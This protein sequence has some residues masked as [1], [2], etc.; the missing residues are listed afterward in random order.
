M[1]KLSFISS[2]MVLA[3]LSSC[4][5]DESP[6][7]KEQI[8]EVVTHEEPLSAIEVSNQINTLFEQNGS[9]NWSQAS[10]YLLWSAAINGDNILTI[11]YGNEGESFSTN[12]SN[13]LIQ[14]KDEIIKTVLTTSS[15][16][17]KKREDILLYDDPILNNIDVIITDF[18]SVVELRKNNQIRY[19]EPEGFT[20][21]NEN[22][23]RSS[24]GC[25]QSGETISSSDY[26]TL[27]SG[28]KVPWNFYD[29]NIDDAWAYSTG[30]GIGVGV[31][32]TGVS[33]KQSYL[34]SKFD[35]A[36]SGRT[37]SKYGTY[38][39]SIWPWKT[40]TDGPD[41]KCG[42]GTSASATIAAPNNTA[43]QFVGVAYECNLVSYR[44]TSD[45]VLNGYHERKGVSKALV[46]LG[47]RND[48]KIISMSI[49]Y[50]WSIGSIKDAIR[51][52]YSKNKLIFAAGGTSTDFT[53]WYGVIFP[54]TMSETV[55]VT[56]VEE[57]TNYQECDVCHTG[58]D[59][60]FTIIMERNN[61]HHQPVLGFNNGDSS[62]FGGSSVAT[63]V[64]AGIAALVW[65]E[66]PTWSRAQ[67]LQRLKESSE[68]YPSKD[69]DFG[70]GN[71]DALKA[72]TG[73]GI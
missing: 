21:S 6:I 72:V 33:S 7:Q 26:G 58:S 51:Y 71:I 3:F 63:A 28:A 31:I 40:N 4:T 29:H 62:Y 66:N 13:E 50:P 9:F 55:A 19:I 44:G 46:E 68:F 69:G 25:S 11:G 34:G 22:L 35:D 17:S 65:S 36:Y 64:T 60:D 2:V 41:D 20:F 37:I 53:N 56:G 45:V 47:D 8:I 49:G 5:T 1:K 70:Y 52:A 23:E 32:D 24:S 57:Q 43:S 30:R 15:D 14:I 39:D 73:N 27:P 38:V 12:R 48:V 18:N 59:M 67:V 61:N 10:D 42:H 54:A 16:T